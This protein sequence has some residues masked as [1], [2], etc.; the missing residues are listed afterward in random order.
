M[1]FASTPLAGAHL[2]EIEPA[3]DERG[4]FARTWCQREFDAQGLD[5]RLVQCSVSF[6]ARRGTLRGM[7]YQARPH[8]EAKVVRCT[9]G[10]IYDVLVDLRPESAT[11][12]K[13]H[14]VVLDAVS[15]RALYIPPGVAHGFLTLEDDT[16]VLYQ[17]STFYQPDAARGVRWNDP[18]FGIHWP[19]AVTVVSA[20]DRSYPDFQ[21]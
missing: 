9:R 1:K 21:A 11:Y 16:E 12:K 15:H 6:N 19:E 8:E 5:S 20:R 3:V 13:W 7:H 2:L 17:I 4:F 14:G 10:R 18:T